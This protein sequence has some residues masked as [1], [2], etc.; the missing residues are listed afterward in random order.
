[1]TTEPHLTERM[2]TQIAQ[3][4]ASGDARV[5]FLQCY[6]RM[7]ENM[8]A[9]VAA[10]RFH[11]A[12]W[13]TTFVHDFAHYYFV[14][15]DAYDA[16]MPHVPPIWREAHDLAKQPTTTVVQNLLLGVNA[17]INYDLVLV[18]DDLLRPTWRH[19]EP[20]Q[21]Q[22]RHADYCT[23]NQIIAETINCVQDDVVRPYARLMQIVDVACGPLDEWMTARLIT[24][25]RRDVWAQAIDLITA[26]DKLARMEI[27]QRTAA[28]AEARVR[29]L[30]QGGVIGARTFGY[31]L[32][33]LR[34]LKLL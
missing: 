28:Q 24:A 11:D 23:V 22:A 10:G 4:Q 29:L 5:V 32:H 20:A 25:W 33:W 18:L 16:Q 17:H 6:T 27:R 30:V 14:A 7:T 12:P 9:G 1:M 34:R 2:Y 13:V 31:P 8:L 26:P 15:L 3:W 19:L 21:R